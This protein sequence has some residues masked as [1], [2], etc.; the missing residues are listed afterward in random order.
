MNGNIARIYERLE[1]GRPD[2]GTRM[3]RHVASDLSA[4]MAVPA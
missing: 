4:A 3:W 2:P 1:R